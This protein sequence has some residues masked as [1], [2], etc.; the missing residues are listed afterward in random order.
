MQQTVELG[1]GGRLVIPAPMREALG[2]KPGDRLNVRLEGR[3]LRIYSLAE[4][5]RR[6]RAIVRKF[7]PEGVSLVD[8]LIAD[9]RREAERERKDAENG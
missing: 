2:M 5:L 1:A 7:V 4:G 3:E 6:A 9:R 8:E